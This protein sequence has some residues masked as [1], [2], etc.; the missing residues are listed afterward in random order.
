[1]KTFSQSFYGGLLTGLIV[2]A[3]VAYLL[4]AVVGRPNRHATIDDAPI[5]AV[6]AHETPSTP[7]PST[8]SDSAE[9]APNPHLETTDEKPDLETAE[10]RLMNPRVSWDDKKQ[11]LVGITESLREAA[12]S[13][14]DILKTPDD[15]MDFSIDP[16]RYLYRYGR[17]VGLFGAASA[18]FK[19]QDKCHYYFTQG[20]S[21]T[22]LCVF[23]PNLT[24]ESARRVEANC[25][26]PNVAVP[27]VLFRMRNSKSTL[28]YI[29]TT[30]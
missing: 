5:A 2:G 19:P 3:A 22:V 4:V 9:A 6:S 23:F 27:G 28:Y 26:V 8:E 30:L 21:T 16:E 14:P 10:S 1:M 12:G 7:L 15:W 25:L 17:F 24:A 11:I 13:T 20:E 29:L 18:Y